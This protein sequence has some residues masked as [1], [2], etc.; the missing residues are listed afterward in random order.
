MLV[1]EA[2][3][4]ECVAESGGRDDAAKIA[5]AKWI[6]VRKIRDENL[7][8]ALMMELDEG[9]AEAI[10]LALEK[11]ADLLLL[12]DYEARR[13]ARSLGLKVTGTIGILIKAKNDGKIKSLKDEIEKLMKTGFWISKELYERILERLEE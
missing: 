10:V 6:R 12:D 1:P 7:K 9:E 13:V 3:Y 2:V 5:K 11:S 4:R 8:R